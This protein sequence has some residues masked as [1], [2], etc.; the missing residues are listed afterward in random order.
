MMNKLFLAILLSVALISCDG[1][2]SSNTEKIEASNVTTE[3]GSIATTPNGT[4][5]NVDPDGTPSIVEDPNGDATITQNPDGIF[6]VESGSDRVLVF[7]DGG[8][9][10][11]ISSGSN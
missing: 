4:V 6:V 7:P 1:G 11:D 5:V 3:D 2:T 10:N 8:I 9:V